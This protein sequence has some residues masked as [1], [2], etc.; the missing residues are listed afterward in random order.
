MQRVD[1]KRQAIRGVVE[2]LAADS[3]TALRVR[4]AMT[5]NPVCVP[6]D[7]TAL[8]IVEIFEEKR[9]QHLL[10]TDEGRLVGVLS[11][12]DVVRLFGSHDSDERNYLETITAG[13]LMSLQ[14]RTI[15]PDAP[16]LE[17]V[18]LM[19]EHGLHCLPVVEQGYAR[20]ILT[21]TDLF[22]ALEQLLLHS[23]SCPVG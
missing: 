9:F 11:D 17:A 4:D 7:R 21:S 13:E 16:L 20:G 6:R 2:N 12:R 19:L 10:V 8:G 3:W 23:A 5:A 22:L 1:V 14:P 18:Q 15:G